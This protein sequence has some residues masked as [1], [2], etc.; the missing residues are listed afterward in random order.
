MGYMPYSFLIVLAQKNVDA[1]TWT[2]FYGTDFWSDA[3]WDSTWNKSIPRDCSTGEHS[4]FHFASNMQHSNSNV[5][6]VFM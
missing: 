1:Q 4:I 6:Q 3:Q 5:L 2:F